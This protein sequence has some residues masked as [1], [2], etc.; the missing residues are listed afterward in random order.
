MGHYSWLKDIIRRVRIWLMRIR[1]SNQV[2]LSGQYSNVVI[3]APHPDD[4]VLGCGG[5][6][7]RLVAEGK[8]P[9]VVILTGGEGSLDGCDIEAEDIKHARH[10]LT[11]AAAH[12]LGLPETN[13]HTMNYRD[14]GIAMQDAETERLTAL[15]SELNPDAV[16]VPHWGEG[17][18]DHVHAAEIVKSVAPKNAAVYE[19]CV[20]M[21]YYNIWRLDWKNAFQLKMTR[22]EHDDKL[23]AVD[24]YIKPVAPSGKPWSGV[25]P[26][27][28]VRANK[29][30]RE[31]YFKVK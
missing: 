18:P 16:F 6:I 2:E 13:I 20:W 30:N 23:A 31:L 3:V 1:L 4:E 26:S 12:I 25:L 22:K 7:A 24:A 8:A 17:W 27:L 19:Y 15:L 21:W 29:W 11:L 14:G 9:H 28:F 10:E 5:L